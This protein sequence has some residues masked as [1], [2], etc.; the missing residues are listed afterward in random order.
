M[1]ISQRLDLS[2]LVA[3]GSSSVELN[4][5]SSKLIPSESEFLLRVINLYVLGCL[6]TRL[7]TR[8]RQTK[9]SFVTQT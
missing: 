1:F 8:L 5:S 9:M 6:L 3:S 4:G 2:A 7:E